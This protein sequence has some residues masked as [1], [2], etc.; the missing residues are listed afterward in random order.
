MAL[1]HVRL[2]VRLKIVRSVERFATEITQ[3][4]SFVAV[5]VVNMSSEVFFPTSVVRTFVAF[6]NG[7]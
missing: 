5:Y 1:V 2:F 3:M 4:R 6:V 7:R